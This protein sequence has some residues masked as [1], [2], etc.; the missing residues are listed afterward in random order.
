M[1]PI[2]TYYNGYRFRSRL[3]ARWAVFFDALDIDY[4]YEPEG[5]E[6]KN[7]K[8]YLPDFYLPTFNGGLYCE[9]KPVGGDFTK[10][11]LF[12]EEINQNIWLC[13]GVPELIIYKV[14]GPFEYHN[15]KDYLFTCSIPN[16]NQAENENRMFGMPCGDCIEP[17]CQTPN[18]IGILEE[19][20]RDL[21]SE[22]YSAAI[23][24]AKSARFEY[25]ECG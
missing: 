2:E 15:E 19:S 24:K 4:E 7:G 14:Y 22:Y 13:E 20:K 11:L 25:G 17:D 5:Y 8:R 21:T 16:W 18:R 12:S 6:L 10:A 3:E 1:K 23:S 9:V